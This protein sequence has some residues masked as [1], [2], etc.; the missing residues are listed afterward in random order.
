MENNP[1][2]T[3]KRAGFY[4][5]ALVLIFVSVLASISWIST[6]PS[7]GDST[8]VI[9]GIVA[10]ATPTIAAVLAL[11]QGL[12]ASGKAQEAA[13]SAQQATT[14]IAEAKEQIAQVNSKVDGQLSS[15][16]DAAAAA[17]PSV[18]VP[19]S[20]IPPPNG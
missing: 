4:I 2:D 16:I 19:P 14:G 8:T 12:N 11:L 1:T 17:N 9:A 20:V 3:T 6:R 10:V 15:L 7:A 18:I 5:L 13:A